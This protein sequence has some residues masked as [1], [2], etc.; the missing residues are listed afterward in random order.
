MSGAGAKPTIHHPEDVVVWPD[1]THA[2]Y[3]AVQRGEYAWMSDDYEVVPA[4]NLARLRELGV[5]VD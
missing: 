1:V 3:A 2:D 4:E 5:P